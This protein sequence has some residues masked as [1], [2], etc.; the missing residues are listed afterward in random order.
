MHPPKWF[1]IYFTHLCGSHV[2]GSYPTPFSV[3]SMNCSCGCSPNCLS[4]F[5]MA[6]VVVLTATRRTY[7][8]ASTGRKRHLRHAEPPPPGIVPSLFSSLNTCVVDRQRKVDTL[9]LQYSSTAAVQQYSSSTAVV[10]QGFPNKAVCR[11]IYVGI[12]I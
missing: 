7:S 2:L 1:S 11:Y 12:P 8:L 9:T 6:V 10:Q 5:S 3:I 4:C